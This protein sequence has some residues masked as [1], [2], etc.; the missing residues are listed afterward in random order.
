[1]FSQHNK[2]LILYNPLKGNVLSKALDAFAR[3]FERRL[4]GLEIQKSSSA[5]EYKLDFLS[6]EELEKLNSSDCEHNSF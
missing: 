5:R 4:I 1:M 3:V 2:F 6:H